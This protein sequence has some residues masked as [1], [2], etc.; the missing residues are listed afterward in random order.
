RYLDTNKRVFWFGSIAAFV[1][2][3]CSKE[4][5]VTLPLSLILVAYLIGFG[6]KRSVG[7]AIPH[8]L[9]LGAYLLLTLGRLGIAG[10]ALSSLRT[11][12]KELEAGGYYF[13]PGL[14]V[15][16]NGGTA[17]SWAMN[18]PVGMLGKSRDNT[19]TRS[20]VLWSFAGIQMGLLA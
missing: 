19:R 10:E 16:T 4:S 17:W 5:A 6:V 1:L 9:L 7:G 15:V 11:P 14:H 3:L 18:L 8:A 13:M 20:V 2:S 12:P